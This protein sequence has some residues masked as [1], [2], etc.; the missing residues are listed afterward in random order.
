[1]DIKINEIESNLDLSSF[2][3]IPKDIKSLDPFDLEN[4]QMVSTEL[5]IDQLLKIKNP[6]D[7]FVMI[8]AKFGDPLSVPVYPNHTFNIK[9]IAVY[10]RYIDYVTLGQPETSYPT[11]YFKG[12]FPGSEFPS[13]LVEKCDAVNHITKLGE[14]FSTPA[15][16]VLHE[17]VLP[18]DCIEYVKGK[19][20]SRW[21]EGF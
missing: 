13:E 3:S 14:I 9:P 19:G 4:S 10:N 7:Q 8:N 12:F 15:S 21:K 1:M 11:S 2:K 5:G 6:L 17:P 16:N 20:A 18:Y